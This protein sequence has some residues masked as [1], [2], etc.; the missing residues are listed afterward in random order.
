MQNITA[1]IPNTQKIITAQSSI[2]VPTNTS[3]EIFNPIINSYSNDSVNLSK[4]NNIPNGFSQN[5]LLNQI[6]IPPTTGAT[7]TI[8]LNTQNKKNTLTSVL[9]NNQ[10]QAVAL[11]ETTHYNNSNGDSIIHFLTN[12]E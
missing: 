1:V 3:T 11:A 12:N 7:Q 8:F 9:Y 6:T 5:F 10:Q 4:Q 2:Y